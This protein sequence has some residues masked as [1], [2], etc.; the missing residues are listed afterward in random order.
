[1]NLSMGFPPPG[2]GHDWN[3]HMTMLHQFWCLI[4]ELLSAFMAT[5]LGIRHRDQWHS[6]QPA[7]SRVARYQPNLRN[8]RNCD[9][10]SVVSNP[11]KVSPSMTRAQ[12][13]D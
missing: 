10:F 4:Q 3:L 8:S 6:I 1:M 7:V 13:P 9:R 5:S 11:F 2:A 12:A